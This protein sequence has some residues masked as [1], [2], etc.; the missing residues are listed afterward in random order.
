MRTTS[1]EESSGRS[2]SFDLVPVQSAEYVRDVLPESFDLWGAGR[3]FEDYVAD[4]R[5]FATS[6]YG[7]RRFRT[8]GLHV[9]G[10]MVASCKRYEREMHC[11]DQRLRAVGIGA[12]F[13]PPQMRGCG[14]A[15]ALIGA[16]LDA[17]RAAGIDLAFLFSNIHPHFYERLGFIT[18]PS[19]A[20]S[21]RASSLEG[22][23]VDAFPIAHGDWPAVHRCFEALEAR[24]P[25]GFRRTP[26]VWDWM[27]ARRVN[28]PAVD[29]AVR[30]GRSIVA[31]VLG[32]REVAAD[33][34][35]FEEFAFSDEAG[36]AKIA[37]LLRAAAGDLRKI[38]GWLPPDVARDA[39]PH[40]AVKRRR[41]ALL[42]V[43]P[44]STVARARWRSQGEAIQR[45]G[46]DRLWLTDAV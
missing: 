31:Y 26:L 17:E 15:S 39:I 12:V 11:G 8:I 29:L 18:L 35:V 7:K 42:M 22:R 27:R 20:I 2:L 40:G 33:S 46:A 44:L 1:S 13:T 19:R 9:E 6:A 5:A 21:I 14:Y 28:V 45:D 16:L 25:F 10:R 43:A 3:T 37:P 38:A 23:K 32:R 4:F 36:R 41:E 34:Y 24:R 30:R